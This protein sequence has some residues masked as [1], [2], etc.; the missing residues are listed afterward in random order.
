MLVWP[1]N[2]PPI[3]PI[4]AS[5]KKL[6]LALGVV[7]V[8]TAASGLSVSAGPALQSL[9]NLTNAAEFAITN[10]YGQSFSVD[11][12]L[13]A[14]LSPFADFVT[15]G[16]VGQA[17]SCPGLAGAWAVPD[18][19]PA[20]N[21]GTYAPA[22]GGGGMEAFTAGSS[23]L[24]TGF[25]GSGFGVS[26]N[27]FRAVSQVGGSVETVEGLIVPLTLNDTNLAAIALSGALTTQTIGASISSTLFGPSS[28][29][30]TTSYANQMINDLS[31]F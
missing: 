9:T 24:T 5:S 15:G 8:A 12:I 18:P 13:S 11:G 23:T 4:M 31:A 25:I 22:L 14:D 2:P 6:A 20:G 30:A 27:S 3:S 29:K 28:V 17:T 10:T 1:F 7:S 21:G 16:R 26:A 19:C